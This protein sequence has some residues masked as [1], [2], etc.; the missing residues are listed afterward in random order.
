QLVLVGRGANALAHQ[1]RAAA[2]KY[3]KSI[4][5]QIGYDEEQAHRIIAGSDLIM[6]PS[7][8]EQCVLTQLYCLT[9]CTITLVNKVGGLAY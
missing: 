3:P 2:K 8:F 6:V 1:V 4:A 7:R 9:Y 5:V